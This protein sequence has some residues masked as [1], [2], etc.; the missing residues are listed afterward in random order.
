MDFMLWIEESFYSSYKIYHS[1]WYLIWIIPQRSISYISDPFGGREYTSLK[2][3][4]FVVQLVTRGFNI[5]DEVLF[6]QAKLIIPD[7]TYGE[8]TATSPSR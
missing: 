4:L 5:E 7:F 8:K 3:L 2:I 1:A 6:Y